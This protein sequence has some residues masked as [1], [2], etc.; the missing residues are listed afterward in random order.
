MK[1]ES[2]SLQG[3]R[4]SNEDEHCYLLN[5][6]N[7]NKKFNL[8]NVVSVFDGHGGKLV[9][10]YL[11]E[12][13]LKKILKKKDNA[14]FNNSTSISKLINNIY[15]ETQDE[16]INTHP[17]ASYYCGSTALTGLIVKNQNKKNIL[18]IINVGD[19]RAV[20]YNSKK[21]TIQL[22]QDHKP[23]SPS[24]LRRIKKNGGKIVFDGVDWRVCD[25]SL[26]RSFGDVNA[27]PYVTHLP[28]L[29]K[30]NLTKHDE[31][32]IFACD[33][34]WDVISNRKAT[35]FIVDLIN[36]NYTGNYSKKLAEYAI[37]EGSTD[38]VTVVI[39][40]LNL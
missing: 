20:L 36:T 37:N 19:S 1:V 13:L 16:L 8:M 9:S 12:N 15:N 10:K 3:L 23:N 40:F 17:K 34:L 21:K 26:S 27:T 31:F 28:E 38:N 14:I 4:D 22:S 25:L 30:Y 24:E 6:D 18:W 35:K 11:K 39:L 2:Y 5:L 33:G 32:I 7:K 29:F